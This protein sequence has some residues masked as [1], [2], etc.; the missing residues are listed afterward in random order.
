M[1]Y[2]NHLTNY[3]ISSQNASAR[4]PPGPPGPQGPAGP[5][6]AIIT[7]AAMVAEFRNLVRGK[8]KGPKRHL[9]LY[10]LVLELFLCY[11]ISIR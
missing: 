11:S 1:G 8:G 5:P 4:G 6:G 9:Y 2:L 10:S 7:E 3:I